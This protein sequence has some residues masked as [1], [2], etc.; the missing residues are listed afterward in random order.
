M[1]PFFLFAACCY[2]VAPY[3]GLS[4]RDVDPRI[5]ELWP[6]GGV[7]FVLLTT[8]WG[9][10]RRRVIATMT[11]ML[12]TFV[13]TAVLMGFD[14][15]SSAWMGALAVAQSTLMLLL[16]RRALSHPG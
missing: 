15:S 12:V 4:S 14:A 13:V 10:G 11:S 7:G 1:L 9:L 16:Y 3:L 2:L 6:P 8:V 5:A